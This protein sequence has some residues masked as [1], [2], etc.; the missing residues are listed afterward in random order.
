MNPLAWTRFGAAIEWYR[1]LGYEFVDVPW[2]VRP[3]CVEPTLPAGKFPWMVT[4]GLDQRGALVGSA[5]QAFLQLRRDAILD[6]LKMYMTITPCFRS[7]EVYSRITR[8][9]FMKLELYAPAAFS[10]EEMAR[11]AHKFFRR[12]YQGCLI[13]TTEEGLDI[14]YKG[15]E[16]GSY[17]SRR[18]EYVYG[19]G[20]AEPRFTL[21]GE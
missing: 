2:I 6:P 18:N 4:E 13:V 9:Q 8:K 14:T 10:V 11:H 17:G 15:V 1:H 3:E 20:L 21:A 19:T 5:E 16:L 7:E 12:W